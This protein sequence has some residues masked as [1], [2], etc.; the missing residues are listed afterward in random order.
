MAVL[1]IRKYPDEILKKVAEPVTKINGELQKLIDDMI[2]TMY[3]SNG[4]GLAAPQVGVLK[5]LIVVD[6][7]VRQ[8]NQSLLVLINP[9]IVNYE[10]EVL[11]EEGCLSVPGFT[12]KLSRKEKIYIKAFDRKGKPIEI[13]ADGLLSRALQH[14][15]DHLNGILIIDRLSPLKKELFRRKYLKLKK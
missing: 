4:V 15:I 6:T 9:E 7:S 8:K 3:A 11:S 5:R 1:E 10:G 2:E 13:E 14:E 12:T